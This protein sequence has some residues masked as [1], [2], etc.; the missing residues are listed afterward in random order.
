VLFEEDHKQGEPAWSPDGKLIAFSHFDDSGVSE[1]ASTSIH[2]FDS[3]T[4][5]S[6]LLPGSVGLRSPSWSPDGR[7]LAAVS[8]DLHKLMVLDLH[9]RKWSELNQAKLLNGALT[10]SRDG[11]DLYY[12]D[13]LA[14]AQPIYRIH[15]RTRER[16][17]VTTF[18]TFL[19]GG[20]HRAGLLGRAPDGSL[21]TRLDRGNSDIYF[22]DLEAH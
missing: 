2:I 6:S 16:E 18:E 9:A 20:I 22:L 13:L 11:N 1:Q 8:E 3:K 4:N 14:T 12:Q 10:W 5:Q 21:I 7:Y 19:K 17:V 15:V